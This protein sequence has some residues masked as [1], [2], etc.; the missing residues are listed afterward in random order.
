MPGGYGLFGGPPHPWPMDN[1]CVPL[2]GG[3]DG[4]CGLPTR[5]PVR[6]RLERAAQMPWGTRRTAA[7]E[8]IGGQAEPSLT[9]LRA[10]AQ[11]GIRGVRGWLSRVA[12]SPLQARMV[13]GLP[14]N[15]QCATF[16]KV[17]K[18]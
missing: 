5:R 16:G 12:E 15:C 6:A 18:P 13:L 14:Q 11:A 8:G 9:G 2:L 1:C 7:G 4:E 17:A 10:A 3:A